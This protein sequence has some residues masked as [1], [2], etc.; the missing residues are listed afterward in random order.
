MR[1]DKTFAS[2]LANS[3]NR[4]AARMEHVMVAHGRE[5]CVD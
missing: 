3:A 5:Y 4:D 1:S 2:A